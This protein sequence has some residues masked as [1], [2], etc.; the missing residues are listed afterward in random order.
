MKLADAIRL[1]K[2]VTP[3]DDPWTWAEIAKNPKTVKDTDHAIAAILNAVVAGRL[4]PPAAESLT[5]DLDSL[6]ARVANLETAMAALA[7]KEGE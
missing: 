4:V 5:A 6:Q 2:R 7:Q 3:M 1:I